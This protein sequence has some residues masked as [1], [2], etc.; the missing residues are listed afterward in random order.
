MV[1]RAVR[2]AAARTLDSREPA[3]NRLRAEAARAL[4]APAAA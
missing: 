3:A 4:A 2:A 1:R